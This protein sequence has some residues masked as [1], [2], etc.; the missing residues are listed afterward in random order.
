[1]VIS[2]STVYLLPPPQPD[3]NKLHGLFITVLLFW[4]WHYRTAS[5]TKRVVQQIFLKWVNSNKGISSQSQQTK[6]WLEVKR[7]WAWKP[8]PKKHFAPWSLWSYFS[9]CVLSFSPTIND[10]IKGNFCSEYFPL[11]R[12]YDVGPWSSILSVYQNVLKVLPG[13]SNVYPEPLVWPKRASR[14]G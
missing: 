6:Y 14:V 12:H 2:L 10:S 9:L 13:G 8:F 7:C 4:V 1:M 5:D 3:Y 11:W